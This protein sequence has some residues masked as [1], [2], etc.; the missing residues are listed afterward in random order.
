L[1]RIKEIWTDVYRLFD[2]AQKFLNDE[3][4]F[5]QLFEN[6]KRKVSRQMGLQ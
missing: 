3:L 2:E 1:D 4:V 5:Y 6:K